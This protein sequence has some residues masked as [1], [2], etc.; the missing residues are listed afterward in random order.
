MSRLYEERDR[1]VPTFVK[2][3]FWTG[4]SSTQRSENMNAFFDGYVNSKT[5]LKQFVDQYENA[6]RSKV[7]KEDQE[8]F[9]SFNSFIPCITCYAIEKKFQDAYTTSKFKE[10]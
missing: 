2:N 9:N 7:Q 3:T 5:T 8:D 4:M 6:L 10:F 1:W